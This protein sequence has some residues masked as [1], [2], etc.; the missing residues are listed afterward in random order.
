MQENDES[1]ENLDA[2]TE[3]DRHPLLI[4]TD[5]ENHLKVSLKP[6]TPSTNFSWSKATGTVSD[7]TK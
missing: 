6:Q 7:Y 3:T 1:E 4:S 5:L 2:P